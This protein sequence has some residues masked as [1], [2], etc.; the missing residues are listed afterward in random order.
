MGGLPS[1][2]ST[3]LIDIA[4]NEGFGII[5]AMRIA[6][7]CRA[8]TISLDS[9]RNILSL[10]LKDP[11][12]DDIKCLSRINGYI[13]IELRIII[14]LCDHKIDIISLLRNSNLNYEHPP[15]SGRLICSIELENGFIAI[16]R[17]SKDCIYMG[18]Y[19][20]SKRISFPI[21]PS[22]YTITGR[23]S[24]IMPRINL[25]LSDLNEFIRR[26]SSHFMK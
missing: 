11:T 10:S 18:R 7:E 22:L 23:W 5:K 3:F 8:R 26:T 4:V 9:N 1:I 25:L 24:E 12:Y 20:N 6:E 15:H 2:S 19:L 17:T 16:W 13:S 21:S 14:N